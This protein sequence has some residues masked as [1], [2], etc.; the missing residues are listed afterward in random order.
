MRKIVEITLNEPVLHRHD[1]ILFPDKQRLIVL[2]IDENEATL[3]PFPVRA[4]WII[5]VIYFLWITI[6]Y[7]FIK[8][9]R[10]IRA[11]Q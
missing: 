1:I 7:R 5:A 6:R 2:D 9:Y 8:L 10:W 3:Y 4:H 11:G